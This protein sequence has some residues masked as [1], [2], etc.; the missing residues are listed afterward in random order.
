MGQEPIPVLSGFWS[1]AF[2]SLALQ[3]RVFRYGRGLDSGESS[4]D[5]ASEKGSGTNSAEHPPGHLAI[6][7]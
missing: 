2:S 5:F 1:F 4:Y 7:S 6:G 3:S